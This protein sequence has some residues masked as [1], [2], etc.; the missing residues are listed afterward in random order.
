[1]AET[2]VTPHVAV[3]FLP[4][5]AGRVV[6]IMGQVTNVPN[7]SSFVLHCD[8][9]ILASVTPGTDV[10]LANSFIE[11]IGKV[12][13]TY[14][15]ANPALECYTWINLPGLL[16]LEL[17]TQAVLVTHHFCDFFGAEQLFGPSK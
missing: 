8:T 13:P 11:V 10:P 6:K 12:S 5:Y 9:D 14:S 16:N 1:M 7:K 17:Y 4:A 15:E 3:A 2:V